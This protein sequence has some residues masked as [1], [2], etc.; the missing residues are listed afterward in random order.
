MATTTNRPI[1]P[2]RPIQPLTGFGT[3]TGV[4]CLSD[5]FTDTFD[6]TLVRVGEVALHT[7]QGGAGQPVLL[8]GGWPQ[9]WYAWRLVMPR[10]AEHF[11][12]IAVD[13]RGVGPSDKPHGGYDTG[14]VAAELVDLMRVLGH[15]RFAMAGHDVGM[16]IGYALAADH[17]DALTRLALLDATLPGLAPDIPLFGPEA[18][19][20]LLW[21]FAFNRKR[22]VN[23]QLVRGREDIYYGDQF[24]QKAARPLPDSAVGF[25]VESLARD[26]EALRA[27]FDYYRATDDNIAQN[28][29]RKRH[30]LT[31]P[32]L[33]V[34]GAQGQG[35]RLAALL[36]PVTERL[37]SAVL[38]DCGHYV[39]E[40]QPDALLDHL[41]PFLQH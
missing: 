11:R 37:D 1:R 17:R 12:V 25:Y 26:P 13:P 24:R 36:G 14:T 32:V 3:V 9:N 21:H 7:V 6:S 34:A 19:N 35:E 10:L 23:E 5:G 41:L 22:S 30:P 4:P 8:V 16:W 20:D 18:Q 15:E 28:H 39:P 38:P 29:Q 27:S 2:I 31:L 40:E 33:G